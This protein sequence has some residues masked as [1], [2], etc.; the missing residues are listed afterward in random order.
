MYVK[1]TKAA[2]NRDWTSTDAD[3]DIV[4]DLILGSSTRSL[5][6]NNISKIFALKK[7]ET[8]TSFKDSN[9]N[10]SLKL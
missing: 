8:K 3:F 2:P 9:K 4:Q 7:I 10:Y 5:Y 1:E 6:L